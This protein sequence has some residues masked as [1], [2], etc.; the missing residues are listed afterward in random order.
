[1]VNLPAS[2]S[3][4]RKPLVWLHGEIRTPP[5]STEGRQE[6]GMLLRLLQEGEGLTMPQAEPFPNVGARCG[7]MKSSSGVGVGSSTT[8]QLRSP[9]R[10]ARIVRSTAMDPAKC[11]A[12]NAAGWKLGDAAD[13]LEMDDH[14][15]QLLDARVE[16]A[17][18]IRRQREAAGL[19]QGQLGTRLKT[20][21]PRVAKIERAASDVSLDQLVRAFSAAGGK[22]VV[23][24][25]VEKSDKPRRAKSAGPGVVTFRVTRR[26]AEADVSEQRAAR[27]RAAKQ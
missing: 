18:A 10:A 3:E 6:A 12:L 26:H 14:E 21:Q 23:E 11:K 27:I 13:F 17:L 22:F 9:P 2:R 5:F 7:A 16:L 24:A 19:T 4:T 25:T 20:S 1:M 15:R 8:T